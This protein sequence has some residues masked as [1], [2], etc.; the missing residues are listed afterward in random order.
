MQHFKCIFI[1]N[2]YGCS[3]PY[4]CR[5]TVNLLKIQTATLYKNFRASLSW[6]VRKWDFTFFC[7]NSIL[8]LV[9]FS[10][11][12]LQVN[13]TRLQFFNISV[14]SR[15]DL[16]LFTPLYKSAWSDINSSRYVSITI[17]MK[18][19]INFRYSQE[20]QQY[21]GLKTYTFTSPQFF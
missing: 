7:G 18:T 21:P 5:V 15:V 13:L 2:D 9:M 17:C 6:R 12:F 14:I 19:K 16:R 4:N 3:K 20:F 8:M 11:I 10:H 1:N